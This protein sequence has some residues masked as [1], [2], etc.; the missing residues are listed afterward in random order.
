[1]AKKK[2]PKAHNTKKAAAN[3]VAR[4]FTPEAQL[5]RCIRTHF[6]RLGFTKGNDGAL[7]LP[8]IGKDVVR[9]LHGGQRA[10]RLEVSA[11]FVKQASQRLLAYF[12]NGAEIDP[13]KIKL[14]LIRVESGGEDSDFFGSQRSP[15]QLSLS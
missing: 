8:G 2:A 12:A 6:T 9:K 10:E 15:G 11:D 13:A 4:P 7:I 14:A 3:N 1:M 5:K